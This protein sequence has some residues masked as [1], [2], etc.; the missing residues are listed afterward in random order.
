MAKFSFRKY[1]PLSLRLWHWLNALAILGLLGTVLLRKTFLSW[2]TNSALIETKLKEAGTVIT[3]DLAK[4]IA[5]SIRNPM[6]DWHIY[7]GF[8]LGALLVGRILVALL[9]EKRCPGVHAL[10]SALALKEVPPSEKREAVH[11]TLVRTG[12]AVFYLATALMVV[13]GFMLNFKTE[14][15]LAKDLVGS[16]KEIH[17]LMMWFFVVFVGGHLV[18]VVAAEN[19]KDPGLIS[20]MVHGGDPKNK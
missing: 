11:Y 16:V 9:V 14:L 7:L 2:R 12:Y 10:K 8:A 5:V 19:T 1:Q 6:W 18:G 4:D 15:G 3:P 20:E 17:E 13:T